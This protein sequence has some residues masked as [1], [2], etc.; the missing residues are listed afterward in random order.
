MV[1]GENREKASGFSYGTLEYQLDTASRVAGVSWE[2]WDAFLSGFDNRKM[3]R[4]S[5]REAYSM[6][7][8]LHGWLIET[9]IEHDCIPDWFYRE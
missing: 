5:P 7:Q 3:R 1:L 9:G 8:E 2:Y 4:G 6:G